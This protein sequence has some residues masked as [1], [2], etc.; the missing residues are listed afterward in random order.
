MGPSFR[1]RHKQQSISVSVL[2]GP[3]ADIYGAREE[4][5]GPV[6]GVAQVDHVISGLEPGTEY[7]VIVTLVTPQPQERTRIPD[8]IYVRT[9]NSTT[10]RFA[11]EDWGRLHGQ[12]GKGSFKM[13]DYEDGKVHAHKKHGNNQQR[14]AAEASGAPSVPDDTST[15]APSD[16]GDAEVTEA[17]HDC[18]ENFSNLGSECDSPVPHPESHYGLEGNAA[19][20]EL[21]DH[22]KAHTDEPEPE[23]LNERTCVLWPPLQAPPSHGEVSADVC[24]SSTTV[25]AETTKQG[26]CLAT[27]P[28]QCNLCKMMDCLRRQPKNLDHDELVVGWQSRAKST[29]VAAARQPAAHSETAPRRVFRPYRMPFPG[30][31]VD[32]MSVGLPHLAEPRPMVAQTR[33]TL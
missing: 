13:T 9:A 23:A 5:V 30:R 7:T 32:P 25:Q 27:V 3:D 24:S 15:V 14:H 26:I 29:T 28:P 17:T 6:S 12:G 16:S 1:T 31:P 2:G 21:M 19:A 33:T 4:Y 22:W 11:G 8:S 10:A 20:T 18:F